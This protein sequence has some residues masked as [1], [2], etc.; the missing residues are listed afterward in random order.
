M[1]LYLIR[2]A[3]ALPVGASVPADAL[4]PLS[5]RGEEEAL[6]IGRVLARTDP[7]LALVLTSPLQRAIQTGL[8]IAEACN[9]RPG[10]RVTEHLV[11]GFRARALMEE[12]LAIGSDAHV[13]LVGHQPDMTA[14]LSRL[15]TGGNGGAIAFP[16]GSVAFLT[17][18]PMGQHLEAQ[19]RWMITPQL[20][21]AMPEERESRRIP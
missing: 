2:H 15:I 4:R 1:H 20:V 16:P 11:P 17:A 13:A 10:Q 6:M 7:A 18:S 3:E 12:L 21:A 5:S 8:I 9:P 14:F 19:L